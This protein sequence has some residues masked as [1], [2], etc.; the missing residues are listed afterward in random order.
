MDQ[1]ELIQTAAAIAGG[2]ASGVLSKGLNPPL[3]LDVQWIENIAR[4][5]ITLALKIES[6]AAKQVKNSG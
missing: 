2:I 4:T 3:V 1:K 5:S 6:E